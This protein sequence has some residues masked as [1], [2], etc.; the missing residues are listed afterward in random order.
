MNVFSIIL[1]E[2]KQRVRFKR[3]KKKKEW[4]WISLYSQVQK[5]RTNSMLEISGKK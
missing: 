2:V 1:I 5:Y 4:T 3:K